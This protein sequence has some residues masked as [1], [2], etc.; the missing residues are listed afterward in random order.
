MVNVAV[1]FALS[2]CAPFPEERGEVDAINGV[3]ARDIARAAD[4]RWIVPAPALVGH[5]EINE[6][7]WRVCYRNSA[8]C[9]VSTRGE[10]PRIVAASPAD[11]DEQKLA[12]EK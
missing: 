5:A 11:E 2:I 8:L 9:F 12:G 6:G 7:I 10:T 1:K 4:Y 3:V